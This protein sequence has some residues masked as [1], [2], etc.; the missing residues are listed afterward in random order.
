MNVGGSLPINIARAY[1]LGQT[2]KTTPAQPPA[3][4]KPAATVNDLVAGRT[5]QPVN[6]DTPAVSG[7]RRGDSLQLYTSAAARIE[8]ATGIEVGKKLDVTG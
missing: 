1:G 3:A 4:V 2:G 7:A 6:F 8:A 5:N